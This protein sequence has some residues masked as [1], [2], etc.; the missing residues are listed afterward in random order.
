MKSSRSTVV[1]RFL[2]ILVIATLAYVVYFEKE[3]EKDAGK[4]EQKIHIKMEEV[5]QWQP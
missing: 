1:S 2:T 3:M 5:N 4:L